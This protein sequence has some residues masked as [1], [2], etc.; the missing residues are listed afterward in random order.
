MEL[1][2]FCEDNVIFSS[3]KI[4][5]LSGFLWVGQYLYPPT[6]CVENRGN[7][8]PYRGMGI[9]WNKRLFTG[10]VR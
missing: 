10:I 3:H 8:E 5:D 6:A 9:K 4:A 1:C 7:F 2:C